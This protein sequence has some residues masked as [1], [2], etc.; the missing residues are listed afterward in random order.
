MKQEKELSNLIESWDNKEKAQAIKLLRNSMS[1]TST[2]NQT[3]VSTVEAYVKKTIKAGLNNESLPDY[4]EDFSLTAK[5]T[6]YKGVIQAAVKELADEL[7]VNTN[8]ESLALA[9]EHLERSKSLVEFRKHLK[10]YVSILKTSFYSE[11]DVQE[12]TDMVDE[13]DREIRRLQEYQR[14]Y[15][16]IF[17]VLE[18]GDEDLNIYRQYKV[19]KEGNFSDTEIAST[20]G[21]SRPKLMKV[22]KSFVNVFVNEGQ[23]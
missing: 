8:G 4:P 11:E 21:V 9:W 23:K 2:T 13:Q 19:L 12:L 20:L 22:L 6:Y 17:G 1:E 16:E 14:I 15:T 18:Q 10:M 7:G 5:S 3:P